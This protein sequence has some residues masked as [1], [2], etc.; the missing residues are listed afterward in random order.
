MA[1]FE[2]EVHETLLAGVQDADY[3]EEKTYQGRKVKALLVGRVRSVRSYSASASKLADMIDK[4]IA[5]MPEEA[6]KAIRKFFDMCYV[7]ENLEWSSGD[8][9]WGTG[10]FYPRFVEAW[11]DADG[12]PQICADSFGVNDW[13][14]P[15]LT[16]PQAVA[17][18]KRAEKDIPD[19]GL[20]SMKASGMGRG[21]SK[22]DPKS[23]ASAI[24]AELGL[25][26]PDKKPTKKPK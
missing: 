12:D 8:Q 22:L 19:H 9:A 2:I 25:M 4:T 5:E 20:V 21:K 15:I 18:Y 1:S 13:D 23:I 14:E 3:V 26:P 11:N 17:A 24:V 16:K 6:Q 7:K 10:K